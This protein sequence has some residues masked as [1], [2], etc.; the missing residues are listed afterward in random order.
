[1]IYRGGGA[2]G[3]GVACQKKE[4]QIERQ[5]ADVCVCV[6]VCDNV[7]SGLFSVVDS[8]CSLFVHTYIYKIEYIYIF[9]PGVRACQSS[10]DGL[11]LLSLGISPAP[12]NWELK[13]E[14]NL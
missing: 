11:Y 14:G 13:L 6:C 1:M 7:V 2:K 12:G 3:G 4:G 5:W 10:D 8:S 9:M